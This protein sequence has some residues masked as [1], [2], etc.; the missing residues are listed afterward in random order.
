M[1]FFRRMSSYVF[2][3]IDIICKYRDKNGRYLF[4][5]WKLNYYVKIEFF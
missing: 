5:K 4:F 2:L 3:N 1:G